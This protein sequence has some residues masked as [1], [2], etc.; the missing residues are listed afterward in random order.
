MKKF[1][2]ILL[3]TLLNMQTAKA[4]SDCERK[5]YS[6]CLQ[7]YDSSLQQRQAAQKLNMTKEEYNYIEI[8]VMIDNKHA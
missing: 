8:N 4:D 2:L 1:I 3:I 5:A 6:R 7:L